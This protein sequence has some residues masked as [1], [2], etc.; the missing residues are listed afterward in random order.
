MDFAPDYSDS[1]TSQSL[2]E[3]FYS[4]EEILNKAIVYIA[5]HKETLMNYLKDGHCSFTNNASERSVKPFVM[6]RKNW[7]FADT[8]NGADA[9]AM[10]YST[11]EMSN[12]ERNPSPVR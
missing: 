12:P 6:G 7:L 8:P 1:N 3:D 5:G 10:C 4:N 2:G 11:I 9:S